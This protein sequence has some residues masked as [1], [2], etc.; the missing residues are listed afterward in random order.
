MVIGLLEIYW[1]KIYCS[2]SIEEIGKYLKR[3]M[4]RKKISQIVDS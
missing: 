1:N 2:I 4:R 3:K